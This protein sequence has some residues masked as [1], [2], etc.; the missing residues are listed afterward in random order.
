MAY[1]VPS[2]SILEVSIRYEVAAQTLLNIG[3]FRLD[4][5]TE[6]NPGIGIISEFIGKFDVAATGATSKLAA[7]TVTSTIIREVVC[8]WIYPTRKA[9]VVYAPEAT[10][11]ALDEAGAP[12]NMACCATKRTDDAGPAGHGSIHIGGLPRDAFA[13]DRIATESVALCDAYA[14]KWGTGVTITLVDANLV[15]IIMKRILPTQSSPVTSVQTS[16]EPRTMR[17]RGLRLGV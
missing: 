11:G 1:N 6:S 13:V 12:P 17:R 7:A 14:Q 16:S 5:E 3:H 4:S 8:Q 10:T 9:R 15:P 2:Q